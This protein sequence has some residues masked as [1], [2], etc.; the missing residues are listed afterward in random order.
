MSLYQQG[1]FLLKGLRE[2]TKNGY[3]S[4]AK[5]FKPKDLEIDVTGRSFI[6]TGANSGIG[7]SAAVEI[8]KRGGIVHMVC[9]NPERAQSAKD[10]IVSLS[11]NQNVHVHILDT[12]KLSE[13]H[14]FTNK[15]TTEN[16]KLD[17]LINNAGCMV[18]E[19]TM[20]GD[21]LEVNFATNTM[22]TYILT[23]GLL[24]LLQRTPKSRVITVSSG[25]MYTAKLN[26]KDFNSSKGTFAGEV[27]YA[28]HKRQQVGFLLKLVSW[29]SSVN[30]RSVKK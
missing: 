7:K 29:L 15:F 17:V 19:R 28:Q 11:N 4:A 25:G 18:N 14:K 30:A 8:A 6:I 1:A 16:E 10:E 22:G 26:T 21:D 24:P 20:T 23:M 3:L 13:V 27:A 9:R 5:S 2:F 12:S